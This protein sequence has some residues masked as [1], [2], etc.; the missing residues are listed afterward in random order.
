MRKN[1]IIV[2]KAVS[3]S[4]FEIVGE[5]HGKRHY[6]IIFTSADGKIHRQVISRNKRDLTDR[7][8]RNIT[9]AVARLGRAR[10]DAPGL[11]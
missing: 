3:D 8:R 10:P 6:H 7:N 9:T 4:G 5:R 11:I 2:R 1:L